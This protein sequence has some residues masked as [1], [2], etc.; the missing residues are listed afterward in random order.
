[1]SVLAS[2]R[3]HNEKSPTARWFAFTPSNLNSKLAPKIVDFSDASLQQIVEL[4]ED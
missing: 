3:V 4:P 2:K 1:L